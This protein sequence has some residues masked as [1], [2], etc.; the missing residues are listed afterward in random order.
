MK[1]KRSEKWASGA[2]IF[3]VVYTL[4][5]YIIDSYLIGLVARGWVALDANNV[6]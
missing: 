3:Y 2:I 1:R 6:R 4:K 5:L